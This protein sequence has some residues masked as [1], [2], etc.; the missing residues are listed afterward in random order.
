MGR[1]RPTPADT[2]LG[3]NALLGSECAF[4]RLHLPPAASVCLH[5]CPRYIRAYLP[6]HICIV[7]LW[8]CITWCMWRCITPPS[9]T[10]GAASFLHSLCQSR[11]LCPPPLHRRAGQR[12]FADLARHVPHDHGVLP[13]GVQGG[14]LVGWACGPGW[15]DGRRWH[16]VWV[17]WDG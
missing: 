5:P 3:M 12:G 8:R 7:P 6:T 1:H 14:R 16:A 13:G 15:M 11:L 10:A 2:G 9:S 4:I 17:A